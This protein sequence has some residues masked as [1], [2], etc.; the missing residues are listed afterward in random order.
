VAYPP[1]VAISALA[2]HLKGRTA[3]PVCREFTGACVRAHMH[4]HLWSPS[5]FAVSRG[6]APLSIIKQ[7]INKPDHSAAGLRP[8][9]HPMG[10]PPD[11]SPR[12]APNNSVNGMELVVD[13]GTTAV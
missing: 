12:L 11:R 1:T 6:G 4:G 7:Y 3:Y 9:T 8:P 10:Q 2:Q 13:G 5:H